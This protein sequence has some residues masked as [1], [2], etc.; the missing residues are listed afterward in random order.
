MLGLFAP[1]TEAARKKHTTARLSVLGTVISH[2]SSEHSTTDATPDFG[3][4]LPKEIFSRLRAC[5]FCAVRA[6]H[7]RLGLGYHLVSGMTRLLLSY[8]LR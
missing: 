1:E 7:E 6:K 4:I 3:G 5:M 2:A 8:L